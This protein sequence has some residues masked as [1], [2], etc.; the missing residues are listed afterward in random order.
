MSKSMSEGELR[1][2]LYG[3]QSAAWKSAHLAEVQNDI[4]AASLDQARE[5]TW[6]L[7]EQV[8][9]SRKQTEILRQQRDTA[10]AQL[11]LSLATA[12]R[13]EEY[14]RLM[15]METTDTGRRYAAIADGAK[16]LAEWVDSGLTDIH[17]RVWD[18][19]DEAGLWPSDP[20][21]PEVVDAKLA[22]P[23][24]VLVTEPITR[25]AIAGAAKWGIGAGIASLVA[26]VWW[27]NANYAAIE[28]GEF[29][30]LDSLDA[31]V[32]FLPEFL[33]MAIGLSPVI[34]GTLLGAAWGAWWATREVRKDNRRARELHAARLEQFHAEL[35]DAR[36]QKELR[37]KR[38]AR[39]G[40][41]PQLEHAGNYSSWLTAMKGA[42]SSPVE[43]SEILWSIVN[44]DHHTVTATMMDAWEAFIASIEINPTDGSPRRM[45]VEDD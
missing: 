25:R 12:A 18:D 5:Q 27:F 15:W 45:L 2:H 8:A 38:V 20:S 24:P 44:A 22:E 34:V 6:L 35:A 33:I 32:S 29:E 37:D 23:E 31:A 17:H 40:Y 13:E 36:H 43:V 21:F 16:D 19:A 1:L 3:I 10:D 30:F 4:L 11:K 42:V 14:R 9:E 41:D 26:F 7:E 39:F 28:A